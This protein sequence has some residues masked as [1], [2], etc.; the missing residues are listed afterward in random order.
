MELRA[1][2][3]LL[4]N[5]GP[6]SLSSWAGVE[7]HTNASQTARAIALLYTKFVA[8]LHLANFQ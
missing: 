7:Q 2:A 6:V 8:R 1:T 4:G 3:R 5:S